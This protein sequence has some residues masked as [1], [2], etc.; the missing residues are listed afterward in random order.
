MSSPN[1]YIY[2]IF[3]DEASKSK[4]QKGFIPLDNSANSRPDWAE[5]W[6]IRNVLSNKSFNPDDYIGFLSPKFYE[7]TGCTSEYVLDGVSSAKHSVY[8]FSPFFDQI[9][10]YFNSFE[11]G[12][13]FHKGIYKAGN[14]FLK[15]IGANFELGNIVSDCST[16]IFSNYFVARYDFWKIWFG[17]AEKLFEIAEGKEGE[18]ATLLGNYTMYQAKYNTHFLKVFLLER[19]V[20]L[21]LTSWN[22]QAAYM[23]DLNKIPF[24]LTAAKFLGEFLACDALKGQYLKTNKIIYLR[25]FQNI[26]N[27]VLQSLNP[28]SHQAK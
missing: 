21:V 9:A 11:Q 12:E 27:R 4:L 1:I 6:P 28:S 25:E 10:L 20:T 2:Q 5:Y 15:K 23:P 19:L 26:R 8:S 16:C 3:Y 24:T 18:L 7:K 22:L 17:W 13:G 14:L